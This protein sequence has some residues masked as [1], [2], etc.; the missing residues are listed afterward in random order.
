MIKKYVDIILAWLW[1]FLNRK[2]L[3]TAEKNLKE[4]DNEVNKEIAEA[5]SAY[6]DFMSSMAKYRN[7]QRARQ[8]SLREPANKV[9]QSG[10][11]AEGSNRRDEAGEDSS[12]D[13]NS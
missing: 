10:A 7:E 11:G 13:D 4:K 3:K 12:G 5:E 9:Q 6:D 8:R 2:A 1:G